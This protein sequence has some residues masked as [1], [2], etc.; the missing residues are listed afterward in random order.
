MHTS[1]EAFDTRNDLPQRVRDTLFP[2]LNRQL[3]A[4]LD[5]YSQV[6]LEHEQAPATY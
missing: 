6:M 3:A 1:Q 4:T 2:L 5:L